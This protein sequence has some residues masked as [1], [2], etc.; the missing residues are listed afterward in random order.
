MEKIPINY[1]ITNDEIRVESKSSNTLFI[2]HKRMKT[3]DIIQLDKD[4]KEIQKICKERK[5]IFSQKLGLYKFFQN[6]NNRNNYLE[7]M[8]EV[9][10][11]FDKLIKGWQEKVEKGIYRGYID[12]KEINNLDK[13][14]YRINN[15]CLNET[16]GKIIELYRSIKKLKND[17]NDSKCCITKI[18]L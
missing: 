9:N 1:A 15:L 13:L 18:F 11:L 12:D 2:A 3:I 5:I 17:L 14:S 16:I 8:K 6:K 7:T 10:L 4:I